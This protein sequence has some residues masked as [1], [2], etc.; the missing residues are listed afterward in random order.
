[1]KQQHSRTTRDPLTLAR[2]FHSLCLWNATRRPT[3]PE[4]KEE[5][6]QKNAK[7]RSRRRRRRSNKRNKTITENGESRGG[8]ELQEE[9]RRD[10]KR[11]GGSGIIDKNDGTGLG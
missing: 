9:L 10:R 4:E 5:T 11:E 2:S 6:G 3:W 1:M 8:P 7:K